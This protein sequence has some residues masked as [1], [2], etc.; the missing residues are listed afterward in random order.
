MRVDTVWTDSTERFSRRSEAYLKYRAGYPPELLGF[1][2][3][4]CG[5]TPECV[6]ADVGS[7]TGLLADL[8]LQNGNRVYGIEPNREMRESA[9]IALGNYSGFESLPTRAESTSLASGSVDFVTVGRALHWF[10]YRKSLLEFS[11]ILKTQGW[12]VVVW[13]KR[14]LSTPLLAEYEELLLAYASEHKQK[15]SVQREM[16]SQLLAGG[17]R[18]RVLDG[19]WVFDLDHFKGHT[20]SFSVAPDA[21]H[22]NYRPF[23]EGLERLFRKYQAGAQLTMDYETTVYYGQPHKLETDMTP[24]LAQ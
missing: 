19:R 22:S 20:L 18:N 24:G 16:E 4:E 17:Y 11:R 9:E 6:V 10:D 3:K 7:G 14:K 8:F 23:I 12:I 15:K 21:G 1:L 13:L 2:Q 5:L